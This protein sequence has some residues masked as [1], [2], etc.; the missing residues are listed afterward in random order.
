M[1]ATYNY[2]QISQQVKDVLRQ[3]FGPN[4]TIRTD[5]G[6]QG[7]VHVKIVSDLFD[8]LDVE[9]KQVRIWKVLREN[10][11]AESQAVSLVLAYGTDEI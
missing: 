11:G 2:G 6:W 10:F 9:E 3:A 7:S 5:E 4:V 8:G 1:T